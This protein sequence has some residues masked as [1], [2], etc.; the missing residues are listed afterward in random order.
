MA[1]AVFLITSSLRSFHPVEDQNQ[2]LLNSHASL[3]QSLKAIAPDLDELFA[4]PLFAKSQEDRPTDISWYTS[5]DAPVRRL[6]QLPAPQ[7]RQ[8]LERLQSRLNYIPTDSSPESI[9]LQGMFALGGPDA[10][11][12]VGEQPVL[13][14]WGVVPEGTSQTLASASVRAS[15]VLSSLGL[16]L[17]WTLPDSGAEDHPPREDENRQPNETPAALPAAVDDSAQTV[18]PAPA[19]MTDAPV[20]GNQS[21]E[22]PPE[23]PAQGEPDSIQASASI[24]ADDTPAPP[25]NPPPGP[26]QE[27]WYRRPWVGWL[28]A[29]VVIVLFCLLLWWLLWAP[30]GFLNRH[31]PPQT[32]QLAVLDGLR[33]ERDRLQ[34][35]Q[36]AGCSPELQDLVTDG[37]TAPIPPLPGVASPPPAAGDPGAPP[38]AG[39]ANPPPVTGETNAPPAS[40]DASTPPDANNGTPPDAAPQP[41]QVPTTGM[42]ALASRLESSVA[43][44]FGESDESSIDMGSGFFISPTLLVTNR[45]VVIDMDPS[46]VM[47]T[48]A[49][50][51]AMVPAQIVAMTRNDRIGNPDFAIL[52]LTRPVDNIIPLAIAGSA[53]KL[54]KVVTAGYPAFITESDPQLDALLEGDI[55]ASP[56]MIFTTGEVS[57]VQSQINGPSIIIHTADMSQGSSGGPLIDACGR[58]IGVNTFISED[59]ESGR[60][61]LY[62]LAG[63]ALQE[64]LAANAV[65]FEKATD[66]CAE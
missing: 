58:V 14:D 57:A 10:I 15:E 55:R 12:S 62:S 20:D 18:R 53:S 56:D 32:V 46:S 21:P 3:F 37:Y 28:L 23:A 1:R 43:F 7:R 35:L 36:E 13:I 45:H 41:L 60:R 9:R 39:E 50:I 19:A 47:V 49:H 52:K 11:L 17:P 61:G 2:S 66:A 31:L 22:Q 40:G 4:E 48:S 8:L 59:E 65:S 26:A 27:A 63:S 33:D 54:A 38:A 34:K 42:T 29:A 64:F 25:A 5:R 16:T 24:P 6:N 30:G 51:G 44:V